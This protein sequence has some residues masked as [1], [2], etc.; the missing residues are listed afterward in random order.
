M[1]SLSAISAN[2]GNIT[3]GNINGVNISGSTLKIANTP[4]WGNGTT[5]V[6]MKD[7]EIFVTDKNPDTLSR[8]NA[9]DLHINDGAIFMVGHDAN[10][11]GIY[12][13]DFAPKYILFT[14][15]NADGSIKH[16]TNIQGRVL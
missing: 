9:D 1:S 7:G 14:E 10:G 3:A 15:R 2:I 16:Q 5:F 13:L 8:A 6:K 12:E 4:I 11:I